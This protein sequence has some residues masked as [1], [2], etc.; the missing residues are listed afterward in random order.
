M[1]RLKLRSLPMQK[2]EWLLFDFLVK[3]SG[4]DY[5]MSTCMLFVFAALLEYAVVQVKYNFTCFTSKSWMSIDRDR[6]SF[7]R[8]KQMVICIERK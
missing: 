4:I 5:W 2:V 7:Y 6:L 8:V 3:L 1:L